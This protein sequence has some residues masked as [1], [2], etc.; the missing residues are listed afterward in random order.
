MLIFNLVFSLN[1]SGVILKDSIWTHHRIPMAMSPFSVLLIIVSSLLLETWS[2]P[3]RVSVGGWLILFGLLGQHAGVY[4]WSTWPQ[5]LPLH[6]DPRTLPAHQPLSMCVPLSRTCGK[7]W[8]LCKACPNRGYPEAPPRC[9]CHHLPL[10]CI[11]IPMSHRM[12]SWT[13]SWSTPRKIT[14]LLWTIIK[15]IM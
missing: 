2:E 5:I 9:I 4:H 7:F 15:T 14:V 10:S 8:V 12:W 1:P 6:P 13:D 3:R 11:N